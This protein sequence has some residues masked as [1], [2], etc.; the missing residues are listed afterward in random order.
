MHTCHFPTLYIF[1][2]MFQHYFCT[3]FI[4]CAFTWWLILSCELHS[5]PILLLAHITLS[6]SFWSVLNC[7]WA[8]A[9]AALTLSTLPN[10]GPQ[11]TNGLPYLLLLSLRLSQSTYQPGCSNNVNVVKW[12]GHRFHSAGAISEQ[13]REHPHNCG[14]GSSDSHFWSSKPHSLSQR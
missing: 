10:G 5:N 7:E 13:V 14:P 12:F 6:L 2:M 8:A 9:F 11:S 4:C 1:S 3:C